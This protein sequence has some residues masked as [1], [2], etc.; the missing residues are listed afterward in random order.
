MEQISLHESFLLL[1]Y[2]ILDLWDLMLF[3]LLVTINDKNSF[4]EI[5][6]WEGGLFSLKNSR[7]PKFW[8]ASSEAHLEALQCK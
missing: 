8:Q 6:I 5:S 7:V 1:I 3:P 2:F 4:I